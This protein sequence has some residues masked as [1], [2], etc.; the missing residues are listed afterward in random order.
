MGFR[1]GS[2]SAAT[3]CRRS[4]SPESQFRTMKYR[5]EFPVRFGCIQDSRAFCQTFFPWYN[6]EH[7][8]NYKTG[9]NA[10]V[11]NRR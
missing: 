7:R 8:L 6:D 10:A 2:R 11:L 9:E 5:P 3:Q 1:A 4:A